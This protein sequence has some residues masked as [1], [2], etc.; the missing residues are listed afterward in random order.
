[1]KTLRYLSIVAVSLFAMTSCMND[2]DAPDLTTPPYGNNNIGEANITI[3]ALKEKFA[4]T[5]SSNSSKQ[6]TEDLIIEGVVVANDA[7]GNVYKQFVI[8]DKTG[9]IIIGVNDVGLY[10]TMT[11][12]QRV[13]IDC[14]GLYVGGYGKMAQVGGLYN[15]SIGR[16]NKSVFPEHV[17]IVGR[18]D[19]TQEEMTPLVIG[20]DYFT[21]ENKDKL[22]KFVRLENVAIIG[23]DGTEKWAPEELANSSNVVERTVKVG[24]TD[25]ILR[26]STYADFANDV[27]PAGQLNMNGVLTRFNNFWQFMISSTD[28]IEQIS[29]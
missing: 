2:F 12:G 11:I 16:M 20:E 8:N 14:K 19:K 7:T 21:D 13:R 26:M 17:R 3:E 5:I 1:M 22:A 27:M 9:A 25:I 23:A 10:A 15:G 24:K 29:E 18:P 4:S 6:V 28:D